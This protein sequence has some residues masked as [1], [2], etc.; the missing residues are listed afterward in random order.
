MKA[1][2]P[3]REL[4]ERKVQKKQVLAQ[5]AEEVKEDTKKNLV[6]KFV[7]ASYIS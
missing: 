6:F 5:H 2:V 4:V 7:K 3:T 1:K